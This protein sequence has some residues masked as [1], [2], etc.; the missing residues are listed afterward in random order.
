MGWQIRPDLTAA[1][2]K[3]LLFESAHVHES[4]A[5]IINPTAF[6]DLVRNQSGN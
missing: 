3:E 2:M 1:Q 6:I 4:G 5:K